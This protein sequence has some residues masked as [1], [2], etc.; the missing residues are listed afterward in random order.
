MG[1]VRRDG[2][3]DAEELLEEIKVSG[4]VVLL[5]VLVIVALSLRNYGE[6]WK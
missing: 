2:E 6:F 4:L 3:L 1:L 5:K